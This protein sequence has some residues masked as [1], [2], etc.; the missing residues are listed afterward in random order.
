MAL[1]ISSVSLSN[2]FGQW[3]IVTQNI[4]SELNALDNNIKNATFTKNGGTFFINTLGIGL[5]VSN[6][7]T[8]GNIEVANTAFFRGN[9]TFNRPIITNTTIT[10]TISGIELSENLLVFSTVNPRRDTFINV[11]R[12]SANT[13]ASIKWAE[14]PKTWQCFDVDSST[15]Y[16]I[17]TKKTTATT[18]AAGIVQLSNDPTSISTTMAATPLAVKQVYDYAS[19]IT[20]A[21]SNTNTNIAINSYNQANAAYAKA[22]LAYNIAVLANTKVNTFGGAYDK[23]NSA[24]NIAVSANTRLENASNLL[25][26]TIAAS[27]LGRSSLY[28][29]TTAIALNRGSASQTL[30]GISIDGNATNI[31]SYPLSQNLNTTSSVQFASFGVGTAPSGVSGE[32]RASDNVTAY[33]SSDKRLKENISSIKNALEKINKI[34]GVTFDWKQPYI[35]ERGGEDGFFVR[36]HDIGVIAQ[37]VEEILPEIVATKDTG[38]KAVNYEKL[39]PLLI[40][41]IKELSSEVEKLKRINT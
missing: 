33:Y 15:Y 41:A 16:D 11:N 28:V 22:N 6:T 23:A 17:V 19:N 39:I 25:S 26:G 35:D 34:N 12:G 40:E 36:K 10:S 7:G 29:G 9:V 31:T 38:I 2:T 20:N 1:P 21:T 18:S 5:A 14:S 8:F 13:N 30:S 3:V 24:Y 27:I 4:V 32:I 37:E